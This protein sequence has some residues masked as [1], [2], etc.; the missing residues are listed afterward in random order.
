MTNSE[1]PEVLQKKGNILWGR[2]RAKQD[3]ARQGK[4]SIG[5]D[6][7]SVHLGYLIFDWTAKEAYFSGY[8]QKLK[9]HCSQC[10]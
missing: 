2:N 5:K 7:Q 1:T 8:A 3:R 10:C 9:L 4:A 6:R